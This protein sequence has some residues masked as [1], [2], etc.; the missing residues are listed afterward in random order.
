ML[1]PCPEPIIKAGAEFVNARHRSEDELDSI[2]Q[3]VDALLDRS[4]QGLVATHKDLKAAG[5]KRMQYGV[6]EERLFEAKARIAAARGIP[7]LI[8]AAHQHMGNGLTSI[9]MEQPTD[10]QLIP[11]LVDAAK[12]WR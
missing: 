6:A 9:D 5:M 8:M 2:L 12:D 7:G 3:K 1:K 11:Y 4:I 10:A